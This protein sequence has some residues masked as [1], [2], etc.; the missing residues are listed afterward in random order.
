[1]KNI[2]LA[3]LVALFIS[4]CGDKKGSFILSS[5]SEQNLTE[6]TKNLE[7][8]IQ[9][10]NFTL[11]DTLD[12]K[13][14]A[15]EYNISIRPQKVI[16]FTHPQVASMLIACNTSM[17]MDI[18]FKM[19]VWNDYEG[20]THIEYMNPEYWSLTHNIKD[21]KCLALI[22]QTKIAMDKAVDSI[23]AKP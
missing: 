4:G 11:V 18:P 6:T 2:I 15:D 14:T 23:S 1:M 21:K 20:K 17:S 3:T 22:N 7:K 16:R 8:A 9:N 12:H 10:E 13:I 19:L 5:T